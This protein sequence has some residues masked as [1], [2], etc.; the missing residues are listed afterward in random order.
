MC[1]YACVSV[2][3]CVC[4]HVVGREQVVRA[5]QFFS[6][7][8]HAFSRLF[9]HWFFWDYVIWPINWISA[10]CIQEYS[11]VEISVSQHLQCVFWTYYSQNYHIHLLLNS[12]FPPLWFYLR[13]CPFSLSFFSGPNL[14]P[15][16]VM[17]PFDLGSHGDLVLLES[18]SNL[19]LW[20]WFTQA[21]K[22]NFSIDLIKKNP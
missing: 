12:H 6:S 21:Y 8:T 22:L 18:C 1:M 15:S 2:W 17:L 19:G 11:V 5:F 7:C 3:V 20:Q 9:Y 16:F 10:P 13:N 14:C 4:M